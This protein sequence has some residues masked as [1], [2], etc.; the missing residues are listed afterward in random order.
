VTHP[1][2][3]PLSRVIADDDSW[4]LAQGAYPRDPCA[5]WKK[6]VQLVALVNNNNTFTWS[7]PS[8]VLDCIGQR[9]KRRPGGSASQD[10][11]ATVVALCH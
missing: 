1:Y 7:G 3:F 4:N 6:Q 2:P 9:R 5:T 11:N 10:P 8:G